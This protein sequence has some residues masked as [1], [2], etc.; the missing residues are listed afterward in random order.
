MADEKKKGFIAE[1]KA[2]ISK[3]NV[4]DMAVGIIIGVAFGAV[5]NS[6]VNDMLMPPVGLAMGGA[7]FQESYVVLKAGVVNGTETSS[8]HSLAEAKAAGAVTLRFGVFINTL[9]NFLIIALVIFMIVKVMASAQRKAKALAE[10]EKKEEAKKV[11][12]TQKKC[13]FCDTDISI[14]ATR[15]PHCTSKLEEKEKKDE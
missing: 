9:I 11:E 5:I 2:F 4:M 8:F 15:C 12:A 10:K 7:D 14:K 3:G 1:F 13:P 6:M